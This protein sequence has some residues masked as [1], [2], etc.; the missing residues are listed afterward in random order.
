MCGM[1]WCFE[2]FDD[3]NY[4]LK[5]KIQITTTNL[6][7][8]IR[9][10]VNVLTSTSALASR[11]SFPNL[12]NINYFLKAHL[13]ADQVHGYS[14]SSGLKCEGF[15]EWFSKNCARVNLQYTAILLISLQ[16][17]Q[18]LFPYFTTLRISI[19]LGAD[20]SCRDF[21]ILAVYSIVYK[22]VFKQQVPKRKRHL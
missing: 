9:F 10:D 16:D 1:V 3:I 4:Y 19:T 21:Y 14:Q 8:S 5:Q 22:I 17:S 13:L 12:E 18:N 15:R 2:N 7:M 11:S 20:Q 6:F